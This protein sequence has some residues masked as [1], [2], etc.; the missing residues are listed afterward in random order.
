MD[1]IERYQKQGFSF[2]PLRKRSKKPIFEWAGWQTRRPT[3]EEVKTWQDLKVLNQVAVVC[4]SISGI[5]VLDVDDPA[6]FD[7][8]LA[9]QKHPMPPSPT[10]KTGKGRHIY[11]K[12]P[13][14]RVKNS[15]RQ[16]PGADIKADGG[17]VV[18]PP[19]IHPDGPAYEWFDFLSL[20]DC[21]FAEPPAWLQ[22]YF[23]REVTAHVELSTEDLLG[24]DE[25][26]YTR[27]LRGVSK[28]ERNSVAAKLAGYYLAKGEPRGRVLEMLRSWNL[29]NSEPLPDKEL[30]KTLDSI[31]RL[32]ARSRVRAGVGQ[33]QSSGDVTGLPWDEQRQAA[34]Q[35]LGDLLELPITDIRSTKTDNS[36]WEFVLG[37]EGSVTI[38]GPQ[39][40]SQ[41][42]FYSRMVSAAHMIPKTV[43]KSKNGAGGWKSVVKEV[44]RLASHM[45]VGPEATAHGEVQGLI[46][47]FLSSH[48]GIEYIPVNR[49]IPS[50]SSFFIIR[51]EGEVSL[52]VKLDKLFVE[53][54][55]LGYKLTRRQLISLLPG[56]GHENDRFTW[57]GQTIRA[58]K[59]NLDILSPEVKFDVIKRANDGNDGTM[60]ASMT[61]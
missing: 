29:R 7:T 41:T 2:F 11:F 48:G 24:P 49:K 57:M 30:G 33:G 4:G 19:S 15:T 28:G 59:L 26:D 55:P 39:L 27:Y 58:W 21:E 51:R 36:I 23:E 35:G 13:G 32:E 5:I 53:S 43:P 34:L 40:I 12:H 18:A 56:L 50:N 25:D 20:D 10:V 38:S 22:D 8:W 16:I 47:N 37:D 42:N 60:T 54:K 17:Y 31:A 61:A 1:L 3:P 14:G 45:E 6:V 44:I 52:Y 46:N 9:G